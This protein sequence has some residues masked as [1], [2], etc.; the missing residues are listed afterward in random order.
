[1][2]TAFGIVSIT[3]LAKLP[4]LISFSHD[5]RL[6]IANVEH[7]V[8]MSWWEPWDQ[9]ETWRVRKWIQTTFIVFEVLSLGVNRLCRSSAGVT[10]LGQCMK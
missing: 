9:R 2:L 3:L 6:V 5:K 7:H 1:M 8:T 4:L 10:I